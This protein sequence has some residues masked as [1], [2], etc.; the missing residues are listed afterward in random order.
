MSIQKL[1]GNK[2]QDVFMKQY[3]RDHRLHISAIHENDRNIMTFPPFQSFLTPKF[4]NIVSRANA[5]VSKHQYFIGCSLD[6]N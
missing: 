1:N 2:L 3:H 4:G 5:L 6:T